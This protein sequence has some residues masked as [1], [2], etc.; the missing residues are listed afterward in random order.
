[1]IRM[2]RISLVLII[3][4]L[5]QGCFLQASEKKPQI[6]KKGWF[7]SL[8]SQLS[9]KDKKKF[10]KAVDQTGKNEKTSDDSIFEKRRFLLWASI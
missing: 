5:A 8:L 9:S 1:M 2:N 4:F 7:M 10:S 3:T 6:S